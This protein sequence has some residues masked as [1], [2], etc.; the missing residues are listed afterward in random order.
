REVALHGVEGL[1]RYAQRAVTAM[2]PRAATAAARPGSPG[3]RRQRPG[4]CAA[5]AVRAARLRSRRRSPAEGREVGVAAAHRVLR[6]LLA[7]PRDLVGG[8]DV[9]DLVEAGRSQ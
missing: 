7:G 5:R 4:G 2:A 8:Q 3:P 6:V 1:L 9:G